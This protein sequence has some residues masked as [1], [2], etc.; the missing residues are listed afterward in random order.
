[1]QSRKKSTENP[2]DTIDCAENWEEVFV[3][4]MVRMQ[5]CD[6]GQREL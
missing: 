4:S 6:W 3:L 5:R 2:S 1:M